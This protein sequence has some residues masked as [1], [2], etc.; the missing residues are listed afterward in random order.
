[1]KLCTARRN[2]E[3]AR[4]VS[5]PEPA[6]GAPHDRWAAKPIILRGNTLPHTDPREVAPCSL[7]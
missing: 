2:Q 1:V 3:I 6:R 4:W 7:A 5:K